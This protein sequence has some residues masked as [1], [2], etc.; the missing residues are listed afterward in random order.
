MFSFTR[1]QSKDTVEA[2]QNQPLELAQQKLPEH[3]I[4]KVVSDRNVDAPPES[5]QTP[6]WA[7]P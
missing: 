6:L 4:H 1:R 3:Q 5:G 7:M 2:R